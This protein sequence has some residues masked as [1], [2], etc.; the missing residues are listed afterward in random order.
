M[1][2]N[3]EDNIGKTPM[4]ANGLQKVED[5]NNEGRKNNISP[6][7]QKSIDNVS[8]RNKMY[9]MRVIYDST[10]SKMLVVNMRVI[11]IRQNLAYERR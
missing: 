9:I 6:V 4:G 5:L 1:A 8:K 3:S 7:V 10:R 2:K 11:Y